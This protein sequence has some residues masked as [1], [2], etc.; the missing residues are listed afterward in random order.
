MTARILVVDDIQAN[1]KLLEARLSAEYFQVLTAFN[2][3]DALQ[4]CSSGQCDIVLLDVMMPGMD[5]FEVCRRLKSDSRTQHLPV[6]MV[7]ALDQPEDRVRGLEV[8]ADDFLTKPVNDLALITRVKS[9]VRLKM[10]TDE[11]RMR[12]ETG[13]E[14]GV[15]QFLGGDTGAS[16]S[17][18]NLLVVDDR[19]SSYE[20]IVKFLAAEHRVAVATDPQDALFRAAD[21]EFD[22]LVVSM[23]LSNFDP[24]RLCSQ[25]RSLERTRM[26][27]IVLIADSDQDAG[28][29]RALDLGVNDYIRRPIERNELLARVRTQIKRKRYNETLR[30]SV[31]AT[32]ELAVTDGLTGLHNRRYLDSHMDGM[33]RDARETG[34]PLSVVICDIDL[35]KAVNDQ[36]GH[37]AGDQVLREF[38]KRL[39]KTVRNIDLACRYGGEEFVVVMPDTDISLAS[40][41]AERIRTEVASHPIFIDNGA[42]QLSITVS[43]GIACIENGEDTAE[44]LIKRAD[45]ALYNAKRAGRNRVVTEAA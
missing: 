42:S 45:V 21:E 27:P 43:L 19:P 1:V 26:L 30:Q 37:D 17:G 13:R 44:K 18:G 5:G 36:Y 20:R 25:L 16:G 22:T 31:Q 33:F 12:A 34:K 32:I 29:I 4:I 10:L 40:S 7:T 38:A 3:P 8:G 9:L 41:V 15:E 11:L 28:V 35:F 23:A 2:G 14:L 39:Q 24:L 6:V